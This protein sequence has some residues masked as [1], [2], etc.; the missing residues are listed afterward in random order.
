[1]FTSYKYSSRSTFPI[2]VYYA[3]AKSFPVDRTRVFKIQ[4]RKKVLLA[5]LPKNRET[6]RI[7][8][9][10]IFCSNVNISTSNDFNYYT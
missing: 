4:K 9:E 6:D 2:D 5:Q 3:L 10:P 8:L 7:F 1:M